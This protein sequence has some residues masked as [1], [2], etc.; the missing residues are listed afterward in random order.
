MKILAICGR[1]LDSL[2]GA[3]RSLARL[4]HAL[5]RQHDL[6]VL[7]PSLAL[8]FSSKE[9][10]LK[11]RV[12]DKID[13]AAGL[14]K[15][16]DSLINGGFIADAL[17]MFDKVWFKELDLLET[18]RSGLPDTCL[19]FKEST[20][21]KL[22]RILSRLSVEKANRITES[23]DCVVCVSSHIKKTFERSG[24]F[25]DKLYPIPNG[26]DTEKFSPVSTEEKEKLRNQ[27]G[28]PDIKTPL[29]IYS[30]RFAEKKNLDVIYG[31]WLDLEM[32][33]KECGHLIL[34][35]SPHKHYDKGIL[36]LIREDLKHVS[37]VG[38]F[39]YDEQILPWYQA[40][41]FYLGPTSREGLSN[42][43]LEAMSCGLYPLIS[44]SS[45]YEDLIS[46]ELEG[47]LVEERNTS[48]LIAAMK[49]IMAAPNEFSQ[50]GIN[51]SRQVI[52]RGYDIQYISKCY[53]RM[54]ESWWKIKQ[55]QISVKSGS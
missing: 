41:D 5:Y 19:V 49:K 20:D 45:G 26:I 31:A 29:F 37:I 2:G 34:M 28:L 13:R 14:K 40:S 17:L 22:V 38:P 35:G 1:S 54:I 21:G 23:I 39:S 3:E 36:R 55:N 46:S 6:I 18:I 4:C 47:I 43:C 32:N 27:L 8:P 10:D 15:A 52:K 30:G 16:L 12:I 48:D 11:V 53:T 42:S 25:T 9:K 51:H 7:A 50:R 24:L 44:G 33:I